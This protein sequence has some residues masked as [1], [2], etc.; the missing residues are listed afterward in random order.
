MRPL[1]IF[2]Q[3]MLTTIITS[4]P[5]TLLPSSGVDFFGLGYSCKGENLTGQQQN[6]AVVELLY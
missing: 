1:A 4:A 2:P 6:R 5:A 3:P